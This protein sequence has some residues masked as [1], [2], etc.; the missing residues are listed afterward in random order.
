MSEFDERVLEERTISQLAEFDITCSLDQAHLLV[1]HLMLVIEKNRVTNL[2]RITDPLEAVTLH[3]VDSLL[4]LSCE[5]VRLDRTSYFMDMGTG[6][7]FPGIPLGIM[8]G[9]HGLLVDSVN[10]KTLAV[11]E[12]LSR[13]GLS[14]LHALHSRIE[15]CAVLYPQAQDYVFARAVA[16]ANVLVEYASPLLKVGGTLVLEKAR[17]TEDEIS[18]SVRAA[19]TCGL[20]LVSRETFELPNSLGHR[21]IILYKKVS[22]P[23]IRLPRKPGE[24]KRNPLGI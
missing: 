7:G 1:K 24:A 23:S 20:S 14:G 9:A 12:F 3:I 6:A 4:P 13:L 21:E 17:P 5:S 11:S 8:T 19:K 18:S 22:R 16:Q 15:D 2:T 10:K